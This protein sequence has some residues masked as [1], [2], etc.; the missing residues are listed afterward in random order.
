MIY[1]G[2]GFF[3]G[4]MIWLL[5]QTLTPPPQTPVNKLDR[6]HTEG[7]S[8][9]D[10]LLTGEGRKGVSEEPRKPGPLYIIKYSLAPTVF[11]S[12]MGIFPVE[13]GKGN[14]LIPMKS[15]SQL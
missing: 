1:R 14:L 9:I 15:F 12:V 7:M 2:P 13:Y 10:N 5:A 6:R 4:D 3:R 11:E 8:K